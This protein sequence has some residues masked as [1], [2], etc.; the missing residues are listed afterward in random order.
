[1]NKLDFLS[2][3]PQACKK[4]FKIGNIKNGF[5]ATGLIPYNPERVLAQLNIYL[6]TP[7]PPGSQSSNS[8]SQTSHNLKQLKK[9]ASTIK[10]LLKR[11]SNSPSTLT[12]SVINQLIKSCQ[13]I[14]NSATILAKKNHDLQTAN[15]K[16]QQKKKAL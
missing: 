14:M 3:Y 15:E 8:D 4:V 5:M 11:H 10:K 12:K 1:M 7:T 2:A 13:M 16:Q 9:Q 6:K